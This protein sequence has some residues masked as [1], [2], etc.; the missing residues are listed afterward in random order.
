[1]MITVTLSVHQIKYAFCESVLIIVIEHQDFLCTV[2]AIGKPTK[3]LPSTP[4]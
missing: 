3:S 1:M 4:S 2:Y